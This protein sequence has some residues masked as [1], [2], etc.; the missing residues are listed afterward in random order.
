MIKS[1]PVPWE[2]AQEKPQPHSVSAGRCTAQWQGCLPSLPWGAQGPAEGSGAAGELPWDRAWQ[3]QLFPFLC[4][5]QRRNNTGPIRLKQTGIALWQDTFRK[6]QMLHLLLSIRTEVSFP[7][8]KSLYAWMLTL[9]EKQRSLSW[10]RFKFWS[11]HMG[12]PPNYPSLGHLWHKLG[13]DCFS[14]AK[15][16]SKIRV[17]TSSNIRCLIYT[18]SCAI[19]KEHVEGNTARRKCAWTIST[20]TGA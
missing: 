13:R 12:W 4:I 16:T 11:C 14:P 6:F 15:L 18:G 7:F 1:P 2:G 10:T 19:S 20:C 9:F 3:R 5:G 17:W 8:L